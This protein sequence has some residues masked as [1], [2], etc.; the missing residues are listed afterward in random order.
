MKPQTF[1]FKAHTSNVKCS[2]LKQLE[3][4]PQ[5]FKHTKKV[6]IKGIETFGAT[7]TKLQCYKKETMGQRMK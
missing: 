7:S 5:M 2:N 4:K 3:L 6:Y 1:K